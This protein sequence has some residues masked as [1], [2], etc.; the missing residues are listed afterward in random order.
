MNL[1]PRRTWAV[2][3][4]IE[5]YPHLPG[6]TL[7]GPAQDAIHF[8]NWLLARDVPGDQIRLCLSASDADTL[9]AQ[10]TT[11]VEMRDA[12]REPVLSLFEHEV[13]RWEGDLLIVFWGGHGSIDSHDTKEPRRLYFADA[14]PDSPSC[15]SLDEL[16]R[17]LRHK[18][19]GYFARQAFFI[20]ACAT[21]ERRERFSMHAVPVGPAVGTEQDRRVRQFQFLAA[22]Y[23]EAAGGR[24]LARASGGTTHRTG[25]AMGKGREALPGR[26]PRDRRLQHRAAAGH[27]HR[28]KCAVEQDGTR[29]VRRVVLGRRSNWRARS[30]PM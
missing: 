18:R 29:S 5:E 21:F 23:G 14:S 30:S 10:L 26:L 15:L 25:P 8:V 27:R 7:P 1:S 9:T 4:G 22:G 16:L 2:V 17:A 6:W 28:S 11:P 24:A 19:R 3:A 12:R 20:D 13:S